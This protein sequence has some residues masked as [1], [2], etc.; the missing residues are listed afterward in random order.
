MA[1]MAL[2]TPLSVTVLVAG[3]ALGCSSSSGPSGAGAGD[4]CGSSAASFPGDVMTAFAA[5]CST[6]GACHGQMHS[7]GEEDLYLGLSASQGVNGPGDVAAVYAGLVGMKSSEDPSMNL[8]TPGD[9]EN[10]YLW[11][12]VVGDQNTDPTVVGGCQPAASGPSPCS[13]CISGAP[14]GAQMPLAGTLDPTAACAIENWIMQG[15][16]SD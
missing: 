7:S 13:D 16:K 9:L 8:V 10:S 11:H 2:A 3:L 6:T 1:R 12:K 4:G 14:C 5:N 15:A